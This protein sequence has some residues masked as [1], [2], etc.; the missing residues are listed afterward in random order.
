[1][2]QF[3]KFN[4]PT[5]KN[6][7]VKVY[8]D[9]GHFMYSPLDLPK[10]VRDYIYSCRFTV[11]NQF[12]MKYSPNGLTKGEYSLP[13]NYRLP[14]SRPITEKIFL[15]DG[16]KTHVTIHWDMPIVPKDKDLKPDDTKW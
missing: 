15:I 5:P 13:I 1:M 9:M 6:L 10:I 3:A 16:V 12:W 2:H 7:K 11:W 4:A 14:N 8:D